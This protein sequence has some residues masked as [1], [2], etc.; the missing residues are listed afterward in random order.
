MGAHSALGRRR[1]Q[2]F[3][4]DLR[5]AW[6][7]TVTLSEGKGEREGVRGK[8]RGREEGRKRSREKTA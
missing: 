6:A 5:A 3:T 2:D 4:I 1:R 8:E 7:K